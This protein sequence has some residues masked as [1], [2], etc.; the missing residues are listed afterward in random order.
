M[1]PYCVSPLI[2]IDSD[3]GLSHV[4]IVGSCAYGQAALC[5]GVSKTATNSASIPSSLRYSTGSS[6]GSMFIGWGVFFGDRTLM[7]IKIRAGYDK[8][9][10]Q[11][12]AYDVGPHLANAEDR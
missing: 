5:T 2:G 11:S 4:E 10:R 3:L 7:R 6:Y 1:V 9:A 8:N 12:P